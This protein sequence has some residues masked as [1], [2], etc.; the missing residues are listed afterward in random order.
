MPENSSNLPQP[1]VHI[2]DDDDSFRRAVCR[3]LNTAGFEVQGHASAA[4][5]LLARPDERPGC[6]LLDVEMPGL[7]GLDLQA[8][9]ARKS[10]GLPIIFVTAHGDIPMTVQAMRR[11]AVDFLTKP[12]K[13]GVL[14]NAVQNALAV[15]TAQRGTREKTRIQHQCFDTLTSRE[16]EV[17]E[18]VTAGKLNKQ[19]AAELGTS[20]R[21]VKAHRASVMRKMQVESV[22]ELVLIAAELMSEGREAR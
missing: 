2:V 1:L 21:T 14:L 19:I 13:K 16:R 7:D 22:A 17:F 9:L 4:E 18:R 3:L 5:F 6:V 8:A 11:G 15:D 20:E 12:I 10:T